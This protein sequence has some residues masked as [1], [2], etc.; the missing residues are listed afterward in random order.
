MKTTGINV[1]GNVRNYS[2][3]ID[4]ITY[5]ELMHHFAR[6]CPQGLIRP[7]PASMLAIPMFST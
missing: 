3:V 2:D 5:A 4:E 6:A 1:G 7:L